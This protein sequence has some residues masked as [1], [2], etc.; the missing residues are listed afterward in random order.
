MSCSYKVVEF[1]ALLSFGGHGNHE[2][3]YDKRILLFRSFGSFQKESQR[4]PLCHQVRAYANQPPSFTITNVFVSI[5][6]Q[7]VDHHF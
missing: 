4:S 3:S 5:Q 7:Q 1:Y 6:L 2:R